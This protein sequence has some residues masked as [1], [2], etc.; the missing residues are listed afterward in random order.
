[1]QTVDEMISMELDPINSPHVCDLWIAFNIIKNKIC[2][3]LTSFYHLK[4]Y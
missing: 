1:M 2:V 3:P 4:L